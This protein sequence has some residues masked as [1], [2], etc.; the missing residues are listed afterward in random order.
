[1][2]PLPQQLPFYHEPILTI[3]QGRG[4]LKLKRVKQTTEICINHFQLGQ[5]DSDFLLYQNMGSTQI[6]HINLKFSSFC[7]RQTNRIKYKVL[8]LN[9]VVAYQK[10]IK[11]VLQQR[12]APEL[13]I[14]PRIIIQDRIPQIRE[15]GRLGTSVMRF[16][17]QKSS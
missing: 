3:N 10:S 9:F 17:E 1:M 15:N 16:D 8:I 12:V 2:T 4:K 11:S 5:S 6:I 7:R 14:H 13:R